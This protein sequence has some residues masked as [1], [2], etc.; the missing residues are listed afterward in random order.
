MWRRKG[1]STKLAR[2][3]A[4][5]L[6]GRIKTAFILNPWLFDCADGKTSVRKAGAAPGKSSF[7]SSNVSTSVQAPG[8]NGKPTPGQFLASMQG[9][10]ESA[11]SRNRTTRQHQWQ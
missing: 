11:P 10:E 7:R 9:R 5:L 1:R 2:N 4:S 3:E 8:I 6:F